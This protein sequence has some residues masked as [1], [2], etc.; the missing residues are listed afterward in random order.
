MIK[1]VLTGPESSGKTSLARQLSSALDGAVVVPEF[2]RAYLN[3]KGPEYTFQDYLNMAAG[4][5]AW[6]NWYLAQKPKYLLLDTD[7]TVF[8]IWGKKSY[9]AVPE[10]IHAW[11]AEAQDRYYLLCKPDLAWEPDPLREHPNDRAELFDL[12]VELLKAQHVP[13]TIISG[14]GTAR[15]QAALDTIK[16]ITP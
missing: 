11:Q 1:I 6:E 12:Y 14:T 13:H 15:L 9:G 3:A 7:F 10:L 16:A 4:Q 5:I 2:A 8:H